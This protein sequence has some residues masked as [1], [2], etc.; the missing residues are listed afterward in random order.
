M[1]NTYF[2]FKHFIIHQDRCGMKLSTDAVILGA[3]ASHEASA[4]ILDIGTGT[5]V[6]ALMLAQRYPDAS[7]EAVELDKD[8]YVQ[9]TDN[10]SL[11][12]WKDRVKLFHRSFQEYSESNP[13]GFDLIVS[14]PPYFPYHLK[15]QD[16]QRNLALH[17]DALPFAELVSGVASLLSP[18]GQFWVIL[19]ERQMQDFEKL[20]VDKGLFPYKKV[21]VRNHPD[22]P[23]LRLVQA[24]SFFKRSPTEKTLHIRDGNRNYSLEYRELLKDFLLDF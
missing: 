12:P 9:A 11:S 5:G 3:L 15:S 23:V 13:G 17:N 6:I 20:A 8:A 24:F 16:L 22:A 10:A 14:N 7:I 1:P 2:Q 18:K 21:I 4:R 19:P